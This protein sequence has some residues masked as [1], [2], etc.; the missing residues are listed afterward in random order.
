MK[1]MA[2]TDTVHL[3]AIVYERGFDLDTF[4]AD[5]CGRLSAKGLRLGGL[6]Q[7]ASGI[8]GSR[9]ASIMAVDLR[10]GRRFNIWEGPGARVSDCRL[11]EH[12]LVDAVPMI[13][14]A[15]EERVDLVVVNRF[16]RAE[17]H[18]GGLLTCVSAAVSVGIPVLTAVREPYVAAWRQYHCDLATSLDPDLDVVTTWCESVAHAASAE[19]RSSVSL[20]QTRIELVNKV[21][22]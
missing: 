1:S 8:R 5:V 11:D 19:H 3:A 21:T 2:D 15:I 18:G 6:V 16:G 13:M 9:A 20:P 10:S 22:P 14:S 4:L 17:T 7:V 12:R